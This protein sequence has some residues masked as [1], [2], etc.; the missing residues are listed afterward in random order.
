[1]LRSFANSDARQRGRY[2]RRHIIGAAL[3]RSRIRSEGGHAAARSPLGKAFRELFIVIRHGPAPGPY[4]TVDAARSG[5][6]HLQLRHVLN[7]V[8]SVCWSRFAVF[9]SCARSPASPKQEAEPNRARSEDVSCSRVRDARGPAH[10]KGREVSEGTIGFPMSVRGR[11]G[12]PGRR[13]TNG[14]PIEALGPTWRSK[15]LSGKWGPG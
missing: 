11:P 5:R 2:G 15:A 9:F 1:M 8:V 7:N 13:E 10:E 3:A 4:L 6:S 12:E 14:F